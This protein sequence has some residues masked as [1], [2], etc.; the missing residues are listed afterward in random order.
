MSSLSPP[1]PKSTIIRP[2][3]RSFASQNVTII[4]M[5]KSSDSGLGLLEVLVAAVI[6]AVVLIGLLR[7]S[8][9]LG[10]QQLQSSSTF[11]IDLVRRQFV[12]TLQSSAAWKAT[13]NHASNTSLVCLKNHSDCASAGGAF[14]VYNASDNLLLG[15]D[16]IASG[17]NGFSSSGSVCQA[18]NA[19]PGSGNDTCSYRLD[20]TWQPICPPSGACINPLAQVSGQWTYNPG[21]AQ[22]TIA[23]NPTNYNFTLNQTGTGGAPPGF[24]FQVYD[25]PGAHTFVVPSDVYTIIVELWGGGGGGGSGGNLNTSVKQAAG[26]GGGGAGGY[27]RAVISVVPQSSHSIVVGGGGTPQNDGTDSSYDLTIVAHG[28]EAGKAPDL[29]SLPH[30]TGFP[31]DGG[32]C[33]LASGTNAESLPGGRGAPGDYN[34]NSQVPGGGSFGASGGPGG[35]SPKGGG[36]DSAP[37]GGGTGG[38]AYQSGFSGFAGANGQAVVTW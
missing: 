16:P 14:L 17:Q 26:G 22:R 11:Q 38:Y 7:L 25:V 36:H 20:I 8:T 10:K 2:A 5:R 1:S 6:M 30:L 9:F 31:G 29:V 13:V 15:Y 27:C 3:I 12:T 37:G 34:Y 21:S 4:L 33:T 18:F 19:A 32:T 35:A 24:N 23:F 28:G